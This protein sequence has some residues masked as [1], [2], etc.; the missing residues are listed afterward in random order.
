MSKF[1]KSKS[2]FSSSTTIRI[3]SGP[4]AANVLSVY[5][6]PGTRAWSG[7]NFGCGPVTSAIKVLKIMSD[8]ICGTFSNCCVLVFFLKL[9]VVKNSTLSI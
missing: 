8:S 9:P 2:A 4:M 1:S 6:L 3:C 5:V 7:S